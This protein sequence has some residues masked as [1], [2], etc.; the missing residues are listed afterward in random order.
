MRCMRSVTVD[1]SYVS[2]ITDSPRRLYLVVLIWFTQ[3]WEFASVSPSVVSRT[4]TPL[5]TFIQF[6]LGFVHSIHNSSHHHARTKGDGN[7]SDRVGAGA[8]T[9]LKRHANSRTGGPLIPPPG[10]AGTRRGRP[11]RR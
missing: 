4:N 5:C 10:P 8:S 6:A 7:L 1:P 2:V 9:C 3:C 11:A